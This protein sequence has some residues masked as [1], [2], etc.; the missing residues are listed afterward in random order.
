MKVYVLLYETDDYHDYIGVYSSKEK[1][2]KGIEKDMVRRIGCY[3][4]L[5]RN[6]YDI[7]EDEVV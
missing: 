1:A 7:I 2:E 6:C 3:N 4:R 5:L